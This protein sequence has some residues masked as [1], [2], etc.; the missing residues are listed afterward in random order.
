M[1]ALTMELA[2]RHGALR[3][4]IAAQRQALASHADPL[5]SALVGVDRALAGVDW[6]KAHPAAV[7]VAVVVAV[8]ASPKRAWRW[9][10]RAFF[11]WRGWRSVRNSLL[12]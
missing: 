7:G 12:A 4:R 8:A 5:A 10:K 3:E 2:L 11:V 9:T 6:L 1:S